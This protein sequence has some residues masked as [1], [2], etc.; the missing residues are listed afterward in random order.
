MTIAL[1][2]AGGATA[3]AYEP[4]AEHR[5]TSDTTPNEL[6]NV[7]VDEHR[8]AQLNLDLDFQ[9]EKAQTV[10]LG[11]YF[12]H[13]RPVMMAMVY[14]D[15]PNLCNMQLE[16]TLDVFKKMNLKLGK[17]F[18]FVAISMDS[19]ETP[20]LAAAKRA[21][22]GDGFNFLVGRVEN[23]KEISRELGFKY[24]WDAGLK[25]F[26]H[27]SATYLLTPNGTISRYLYGIEFAPDTLRL[28]LIEAGE[29]KIGSI[30][31]QIVLYCFQFNPN[32][33]KYVIYSYNIMRIGM[34]LMVILLSIFLIPPWWRE[35][36]RRA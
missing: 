11:D 6:I 23:V 15:C 16:G 27:A 10:K 17:D 5:E 26:D 13:G 25:Q 14:F 29:G 35:R 9:N 7:G 31:D 3:V 28:G 30:V 8:G 1:V 32:K 33:N 21:K 36:Q 19:N 18:D 24:K 2:C 4:G 34:I 20:D 12:N 22:F